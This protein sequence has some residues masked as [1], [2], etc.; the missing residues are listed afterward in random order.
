MLL[1]FPDGF[2]RLLMHRLP[3]SCPPPSQT[4]SH[5]CYNYMSKHNVHAHHCR[6]YQPS[7]LVLLAGRPQ[8]TALLKLPDGFARLPIHGLAQWHPPPLSSL[9]QVLQSHTNARRACTSLSL[10]PSCRPHLLLLAGRSRCSAAVGAARRLWP[11][12]D[13]RPRPIPQPSL[14]HLH[15]RRPKGSTVAAQAEQ[16]TQQQQQQQ[17]TAG[18]AHTHTAALSCSWCCWYRGVCD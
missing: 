9:T 15:G 10:I 17:C 4:S 6:L 2:T 12:A 11:A 1:G 8:C 16:H 13:A 3:Q 5:K 18:G 7:S 14:H